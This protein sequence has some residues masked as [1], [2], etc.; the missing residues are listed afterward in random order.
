MSHIAHFTFPP[1]EILSLALGPL[2]TNCY[3]VFHPQHKNAL[4]IDPADSPGLILST[5]K[6][7][8]LSPAA[9]LLTHGHCD[10]I[11]AA[12]AL[13]ARQIPIS[14]HPADA[15]M[16]ADLEASGALFFGLQQESCKPTR[17]LNEGDMIDFWEHAFA[18]RVI[19]TPGHSPGSICL[20]FIPSEAE[21]A[22]G[23]AFVGD[24]LFAGGVGRTDLPGGNDEAMTASLQRLLELPDTTRI[25]PGHGP[26]TTIGQ[27]R[28]QNPFLS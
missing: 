16:L 6:E 8:D 10:H 24:V 15:S 11:G 4:I 18:L 17:L 13:A 27:E 25:C 28:R 14:I 5:L 12:A 22:E 23:C 1:V 21:G 2:Q 3:L 7:R 26:P 9:A 20:L 19:H